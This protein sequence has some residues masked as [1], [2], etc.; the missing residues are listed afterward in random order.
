MMWGRD[1]SMFSQRGGTLL[2]VVVLLLTLTSVATFYTGKVKSFE[3]KILL[4]SQN[5]FQAHNVAEMG[6]ARAISELIEHTGW[7]GETLER[8]LPGLGT[9]AVL[10]AMQSIEKESTT[11]QLFT[12]SSQGSS[13]DGLVSLAVE[14]QLLRY[15]VLANLPDAPFIVAGGF[16]SSGRFSVVANPN[17]AGNGIPLSVWSDLSVDLS[18]GISCGLY[19]YDQGNC[20]TDAYSNAW[21][22]GADILDNDGNFPTD[23]FEYLFNLPMTDWPLLEIEANTLTSDCSGLNNDTS[24][25]VW[26]DGDCVIVNAKHIGNINNPVILIVCDGSLT[27]HAESQITGMVYLFRRPGT[28]G[29]FEVAMDDKAR[30]MGSL[31]ANQPAGTAGW[32]VN[33]IHNTAVLEQLQQHKTLQ[34]VTRVPGS[35]RDF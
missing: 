7:T 20:D 32:A 19:E 31:V 30:I 4:N 28:V 8:I 21:V 15:P 1:I 33:V 6:L 9:F 16:G 11:M 5:Q 26:I 25:L 12:V 3:Y 13:P 29:P 2:T 18:H 24:G 22:R 23:L 34:R 17:G 35:W 10:G 27:M 14:E